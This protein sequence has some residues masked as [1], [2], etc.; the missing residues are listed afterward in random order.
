MSETIITVT[1]AAR[2]FADCINRAHYQRQS[3]LLLKNG[4]PFARI[5]PI[6]EPVSGHGRDI[7]EALANVE[8]PPDEA[9]DWSQD[10]KT[11]RKQLEPPQDKWKSSSTQT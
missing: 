11:A 5:V 9:V 10:L 8:L 2:N 4:V 1:E 7:A 3:F 6:Q